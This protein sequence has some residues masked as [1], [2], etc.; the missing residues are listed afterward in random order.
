[1][2][3][4]ERIIGGHRLVAG[5]G[6]GGM[7]RVYLAISQ[8]QFGFTK[9]VVLKVL[10]E[11][12]DPDGEFLSMFVDEAKLAARLNHP[13]VVQTYEVGMDRDRHF[14]AMEYLEGQSLSGAIS[15]IG[16]DKIPLGFQLR[17]LCDVLE[18]LHYAHELTD[19]DGTPLGIVHRDVSPQNVFVTYTG[20]AKLLDFG[21]AKTTSSVRTTMGVLKGKAGY[22]A[23]EQAVSTPPDRRTDLYA[24]GVM[25]WEAIARQRLV[26]RTDDDVVAITRRLSGLDPKIREVVPDAPPV[27]ADICDKAMARDRNDRWQSAEELRVALQKFLATECPYDEREVAAV[28]GEAFA[29]ERTRIRRLID[30]QQKKGLEEGPMLNLKGE[31]TVVTPPPHAH[32][33][34]SDV[35]ELGEGRPTTVSSTSE[36]AFSSSG[37]LTLRANRSRGPAAVVIGVL[38]VAG[39]GLAVLA[40]STFLKPGSGPTS[41]GAAGSATTVTKGEAETGEPATYRLRI[42][43]EPPGARIYD[44]DTMIGRTPTDLPMTNAALRAAPRQIFIKQD[45]YEPYRLDPVP[46]SVDVVSHV[47]LMKT[48]A[49]TV[50][51]TA[52]P[53]NLGF[54]PVPAHAPTTKPTAEPTPSVTTTSP[55]LGIDPAPTHDLRPLDNANPWEKKK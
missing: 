35:D 23:P 51:P 9:L 34:R 43:S 55:R 18:G 42:T 13:H 33:M 3:A 5:L 14:I 53:P 41:V 48:A 29:E 36:K 47:E 54:R 8:K 17:V 26:K 2:S 50:T 38:L 6:S 21:I 32:A 40:R 44:G 49:V 10:R 15:R 7:A 37:T 39:I 28:L 24:I 30:E 1:M 45:G 31:A 27:L 4:S 19:Y 12:L 11:E 25:I 22:M 20:Q 46:S 16:A 52:T